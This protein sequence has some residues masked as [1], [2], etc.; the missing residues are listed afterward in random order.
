MVAGA[1]GVDAGTTGVDA[2]GAGVDAVAA[3]VDVG[4]ADMNLNV[5][6]AAIEVAGATLAGWLLL[7]PGPTIAARAS[8]E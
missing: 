2:G 6:V 8:A 3:C 4:E 1:A 5:G 7:R